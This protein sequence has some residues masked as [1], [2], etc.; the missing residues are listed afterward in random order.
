MAPASALEMVLRRMV[1]V[2]DQ[3][4][5]H[6]TNAAKCKDVPPCTWPQ[7]KRASLPVS[8]EIC[9]RKK[10]SFKKDQVLMRCAEYSNVGLF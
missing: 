9:L 4:M 5:V 7:L 3:I 8:T 10:I 2:S 6:L 1:F